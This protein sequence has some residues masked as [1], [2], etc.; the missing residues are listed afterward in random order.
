MQGLESMP[1]PR[2]PEMV[3]ARHMPACAA[4]A[5]GP[6]CCCFFP[7]HSWL[8]CAATVADPAAAT[9]LV[10]CPHMLP[11]PLGPAAAT[12]LVSY[13]QQL[14]SMLRQLVLQL[15][16]PFLPRGFFARRRPRSVRGTMFPGARCCRCCRRHSSRG[17]S[18]TNPCT[19]AASTVS[20]P[21]HPGEEKK[22]E[23]IPRRSRREM[24]E[25]AAFGQALF[26]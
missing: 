23:K 19:S 6:S 14:T 17:A 18:R 4:T 3:H 21:G 1:I 11:L 9:V 10:A 24:R 12:V 2:P 7:R 26:Q 13:V 25:E 8:V 16:S 5:A 22:E 20:L 15:H